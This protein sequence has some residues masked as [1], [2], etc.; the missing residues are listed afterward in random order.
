LANG[1]PTDPMP[2]DVDATNGILFDLLDDPVDV[3]DP[4][5][6]TGVPISG[7]WALN[8]IVSTLVCDGINWPLA[9]VGTVRI[10]AQQ[11]GLLYAGN[12]HNETG[13][14]T[15]QGSYTVSNGDTYTNL[16]QVGATDRIT[17]TTDIDFA[18]GDCTLNA[19]FTL[20]LVDPS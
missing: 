9:A 20:Q 19:P 16:L 3:A 2:R 4:L 18:S 6:F 14:A 10:E 1:V 17:G 11:D 13:P 5:E 12:F 8:Y 15:Y 7:E